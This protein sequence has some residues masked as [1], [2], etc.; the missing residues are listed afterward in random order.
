MAY[1]LASRMVSLGWL[2]DSLILGADTWFS[3]IGIVAP[4]SGLPF[5]LGMGAMMWAALVGHL[6]YGLAVTGGFA[7]LRKRLL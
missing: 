7:L 2:V 5:L 6:V 3:A 4:V 1:R